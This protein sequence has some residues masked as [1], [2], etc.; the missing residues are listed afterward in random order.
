LGQRLLLHVSPGFPL[1]ASFLKKTADRECDQPFFCAAEFIGLPV[2]SV[3]Q[4]QFKLVAFLHEV[5][6]HAAFEFLE[7]VA[8]L[9]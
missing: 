8:V 7:P 6:W 2:F 3:V 5:F 1:S 4:R 9:F